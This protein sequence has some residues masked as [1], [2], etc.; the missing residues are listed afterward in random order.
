MN[1]LL[2]YRILAHLMIYSSTDYGIK[3][4][5]ADLGLPE[6]DENIRDGARGQ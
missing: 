2:I 1:T 4:V 6:K 3:T 5:T